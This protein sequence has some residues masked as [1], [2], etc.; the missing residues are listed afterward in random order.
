MVYIDKKII[1]STAVMADNKLYRY[2]LTR[3]WEKDKEIVGVVM[4]NPSRANSLK[5]D[6]TIM[7]LTNYLIDNNYGGVDIVNMYALMATKPSELQNRDQAYEAYNDSHITETAAERDVLVIAWGSDMKKYVRRKR[8]IETLLFPYA[9][10][11]KC[12]E[13]PEGKSPRHPLLLS[14]DWKLVPY[15][16]RYI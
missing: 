10:K 4:L 2:R 13:D 12:L 14:K 16:F 1:E 7:N 5:T 15:S 8:E 6:D 9:H 11:I 3:I